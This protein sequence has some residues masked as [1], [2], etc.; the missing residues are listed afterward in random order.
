AQLQS[1]HQILRKIDGGFH[2]RFF[3]R[4]SSDALGRA[5]AARKRSAINTRRVLPSFTAAI[6]SSRSR[7]SG[8][9][10]VIFINPVSQLSSYLSRSSGSPR[11]LRQLA[12]VGSN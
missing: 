6:F 7:S 8:K 10:S 9:C 3:L 12:E 5:R 1:A 4:W 11:S 2:G